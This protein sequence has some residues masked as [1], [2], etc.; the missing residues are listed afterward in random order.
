MNAVAEQVG[1]RESAGKAE[2][3]AG[4]AIDASGRKSVSVGLI[5]AGIG[6]TACLV[7]GLT[8]QTRP[9]HIDE[10]YHLLVGQSWQ[11]D[12]NFALLDGSYTRAW[13]FTIIVG[14]FFDLFGQANLVIARLP[15]VLAMSGCAALLFQW[16]ARPGRYV[17]AFCAVLLFSMAAYSFDI[18]HFARFYAL[19]A[20]FI[21]GAAG[22]LYIAARRGEPLRPLWVGMAIICLVVALHL[23]PVTVIAC[24]GLAI[25]FGWERGAVLRGVP[26]AFVLLACSAGLVG[27]VLVW[28]TWPELGTVID[29]YQ[30]AERWAAAAQ[31]DRLYYLREWLVQIPALILLWPVALVLAW[32][33]NPSL[34]ALCLCMVASSL[35]LHSFAG[36][37]A[38]RYIY[39]VFPFLCMPYGL[40]I[41]ALFTQAGKDSK[42]EMMPR[43]F[44]GAVRPV[45]VTAMALLLLMGASPNYRHSAK[46]LAAR[47]PL[48]ARHP[49][50][51][52][53]PVPDG[54]WNRAEPGLRRA[55]ADNNGVIVTGD[56]LRTMAH[57]GP[58]DVFISHSRL[59]ELDPPVDFTRDHRTGRALIDSGKALEM[60]VDCN[61]EGVVMV[62]DKQWRSLMGVRTDVADTIERRLT[63]VPAPAGFH[64]YRWRH[65]PAPCANRAAKID[66]RHVAGFS[67]TKI[68]RLPEMRGLS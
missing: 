3:S 58:F 39:Y 34:A 54:D 49:Q 62:S 5:G 7:Y 8:I 42:S 27:L 2:N 17:G 1:R 16:V 43:L 19:H 38:W 29:K 59:G 51:L 15:S 25:W 28:L 20:L 36:M 46:M 31:N 48:V 6:V 33:V 57:V 13:L 52:A 45:V 50:L 23:Q 63:S 61:V 56:D 30:H 55:V 12:G 21:L 24:V 14:T 64:L 67:S 9:A 37:K 22:C 4:P 47:L 10:F 26:P 18:G 66:I 32:R 11:R 40:A 35:L 53:G 65:G 44:Q 68:G 41:D 60:V